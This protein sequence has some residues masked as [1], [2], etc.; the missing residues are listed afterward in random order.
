M[1]KLRLER[2]EASLELWSVCCGHGALICPEGANQVPLHAGLLQLRVQSAAQPLHLPLVGVTQLVE[3]VDTTLED[4][5]DGCAAAALVLG[6][7]LARLR[8]GALALVLTTSD[9]PSSLVAG[10]SRLGRTLVQVCGR[11]D[12]LGGAIEIVFVEEGRAAI[13]CCHLSPSSQVDGPHVDDNF[14]S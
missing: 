10:Y 13:L 12:V 1:T 9:A 4:L 11:P 5:V 3:L 8:E 7:A 6:T 14:H 2:L